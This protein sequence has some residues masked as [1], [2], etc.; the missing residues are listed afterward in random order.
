CRDILDPMLSGS[1]ENMSDTCFPTDSSSN[2][3]QELSQPP[4]FPSQKPAVSRSV[5]KVRFAAN[6]AK[7]FIILLETPSPWRDLL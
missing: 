1:V 4:V 6:P 2:T 5:R 7:R 3:P